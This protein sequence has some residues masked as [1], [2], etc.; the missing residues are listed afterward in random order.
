MVSSMTRGLAVVAA[1]STGL[2][3]G[4]TVNRALVQL[5]T[6]ERIGLIPWANFTR[7]ENVG[8][9]S[10]FYPVL[11]LAALLLTLAA[12]IAF[13]LDRGTRGSRGFPI[14]SAA[15]LVVAWAVVTRGVLVPAMFSLRVAGN[16]TIELQGIFLTVV[17]WSRVNDILHVLT[18][19]LNLWGLIDVSSISNTNLTKGSAELS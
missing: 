5:P 14:Y 3:A 19:G 17:R 6:W 12:A 13:R 16:D 4:V 10:V 18:F 15:V 7:A 2:L 11:G 9:E 8:L 1:L